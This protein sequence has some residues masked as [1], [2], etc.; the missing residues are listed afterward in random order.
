[1]KHAFNFSDKVQRKGRNQLELKIQGLA[2]VLYAISLSIQK[3]R[4]NVV[5]AQSITFFWF[6]SCACSDLTGLVRLE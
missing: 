6:L 1:M 5:F 3:K 4:E 2:S